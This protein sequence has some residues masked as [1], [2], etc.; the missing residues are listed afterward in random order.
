MPAGEQHQGFKIKDLNGI[1]VAFRAAI[2]VEIRTAIE[3]SAPITESV[4]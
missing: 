3:L 4:I 2:R 1:R